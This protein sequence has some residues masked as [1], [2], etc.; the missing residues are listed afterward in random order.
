MTYTTFWVTTLVFFKDCTEKITVHS[1]IKIIHSISEL[2]ED[3]RIKAQE[4]TVM[5]LKKLYFPL[6]ADSIIVINTETESWVNFKVNSLIASVG[7]E[8]ADH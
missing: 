2:G 1:R 3:V 5:K 7:L 4:S 8:V 6:G